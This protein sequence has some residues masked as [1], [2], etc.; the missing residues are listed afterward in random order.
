MTACS[1]RSRGSS[2]QRA[3]PRALTAPI[4]A[5]RGRGR[6]TSLVAA[7]NTMG[8]RSAWPARVNQRFDLTNAPAPDPMARAWQVLKDESQRLGLDQS[9]Y[10]EK[11]KGE[12][13]A[14]AKRRPGA[15]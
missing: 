2:W 8:R 3:P 4:R 9:G 14:R 15:A 1:R 5:V 11:I 10:K 7:G 6:G 12:R 13:A